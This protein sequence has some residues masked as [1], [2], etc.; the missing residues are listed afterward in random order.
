LCSRGAHP[1]SR[2][3][4][5]WPPPLFGHDARAR[6]PILVA[7]VIVGLLIA[8]SLR[9]A[10]TPET[11]YAVPSGIAR[12]CSRD[13]TAEILSWI[14]SVPNGSTL[15]FGAGGCYRIEGTLELRG[16]SGLTFDG[17]GAAFRSF[18][19]P[20]DQ[21]SIWRVI[22]STSVVFRNMIIRG[23]YA[24]GGVHTES[25]QHAHAIDLRGTSAEV[26]NVT[27]SDMAGDCIYLGLGYLSSQTRSSGSIHDVSCSRV[28]RNGV[29][30]T[31]GDD[32][33]IERVTTDRIGF[34]AFDIEPNGV[35][36]FGSRRVSVVNNTIGSYDLYAYAIAGSGPVS[37]QVFA[38][39]R[40]VGERLAVGIITP[41]GQQRSNV[42]IAGNVS[43]TAQWSPAMEIQR[44]NGLTVDG[45]TVPMTGGTMA[46]VDSSCDV[47]V[48]NNSYPGG[49]REVLV[50]N[51]PSSCPA[52]TVAPTVGSF[53]PL[54]GSVG[55]S[56][57]ITGSGFTG[58][59]AVKFNGVAAAFS[60]ASASRI[61][62]TV[63]SGAG[64]GPISVAT[65]AGTATSAAGFSVSAPI[66]A[67]TVGSFSP[68]SGPVGTSVTIAGSGFTGANGVKFNG[69]AAAFSVASASRITATVPSGAGSG[70]ISIVTPAGTATSATD[71]SL[72]SP[73]P[74]PAPPSPPHIDAFTPTFAAVGATV[75]VTGAGF[76]GATEVE[77]DRVPALY[78]VDSDSQLTVIVPLA[79][80]DGRITVRTPAG[81][82]ASTKILHLR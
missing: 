39:N 25:M 48:T 22:D 37:D 59:N 53:S 19:A 10:V 60:V 82:D 46:T 26:S 35:P 45:N 2:L 55:T 34:I 64:S 21:R 7:C 43:D 5:N 81:L 36:G 58:A 31:A 28:G 78:T 63:P 33:R 32:I 41:S 38:N 3:V 76:T 42:T 30:V 65:P 11:N 1:K 57:T 74:S 4:T 75:V 44:V 20:D 6:T 79:G 77:I 66:E 29:S 47:D 49:S 51:T 61:T 8:S 24:N 50:T 54:A 70:P 18:N 40:V 67:P 16:R 9:A 17:N 27:A 73:A 62:A 56:V 15:T 80:T 71:F 12:D 14:A 13:V 52:P 69:V 68:L 23:S 72:L